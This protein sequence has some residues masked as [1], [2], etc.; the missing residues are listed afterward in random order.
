MSCAEDERVLG[1]A[2]A[3]SWPTSTRTDEVAAQP[4]AERKEEKSKVNDKSPNKNKKENPNA[5]MCSKKGES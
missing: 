4:E 3:F 5:S 1:K 2:I